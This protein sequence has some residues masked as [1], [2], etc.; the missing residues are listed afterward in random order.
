VF[1]L[2]HPFSSLLICVLNDFTTQ[3]RAFASLRESP[4][5]ARQAAKIAKWEELAALAANKEP[6]TR[7]QEQPAAP[8][9]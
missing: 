1:I 2:F 7:N 3:L 8:G 5:W 4:Y 9:G 6:R